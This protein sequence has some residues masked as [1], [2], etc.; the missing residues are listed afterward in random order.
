MPN[1]VTVF[2]CLFVFFLCFVSFLFCKKTKRT[3]DSGC[4]IRCFLLV[5]LFALFVLF[6]FFFFLLI[7]F[8]CF[9]FWFACFCFFFCFFLG[10][11]CLTPKKRTTNQK[12]HKKKEAHFGIRDPSVVTVFPVCFLVFVFSFVSFLRFCTKKRKKKKKTQQQQKSELW[13]RDAQFGVCFFC[14]FALGFLL[15]FFCFFVSFLYVYFYFIFSLLFCFVSFVVLV[16]L[17]CN[18]KKKKKK[19]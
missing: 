18:K 8:F 19:N 10:G 7:H 14:C 9:V 15:L 1:L 12:T 16:F 11:F 4:R 2:V 6:L 13:N 3:L 17:C 5:F